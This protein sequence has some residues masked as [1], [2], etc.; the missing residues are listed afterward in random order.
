MSQAEYIGYFMLG[1]A[2]L[3]GVVVGILN[4]IRYAKEQSKHAEQQSQALVD[5]VTD[6]RIVVAKMGENVENQTSILSQIDKRM[7]K[8]EKKQAEQELN[9]ARQ[10]HYKK[11][12]EEN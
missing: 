7:A 3:V 11:V 8:V 6:L 12:R 9:C 10:G 1:T 5:V 4:I 2:F